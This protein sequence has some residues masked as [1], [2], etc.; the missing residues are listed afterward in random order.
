MHIRDVFQKWWTEVAARD[1]STSLQSAFT[2]GWSI[3]FEKSENDARI[4]EKLIFAALRQLVPN[5]NS[6]V[7]NA[8]V[9]KRSEW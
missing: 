9:N 3:G 2:D 5:F 4:R 6:I 1:G 7:V 8:V